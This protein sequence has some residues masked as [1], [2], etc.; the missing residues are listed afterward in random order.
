MIEKGK[1]SAAQLGLLFYSV[2]AYDGILYIPKITGKEAGHDLWLSPIWAHLLGLLF[3]LA[4]LRL[5]SMFPKETIIQY[6]ERLLGNWPGKAVGLVVILYGINLTSVVLREF[7]DFISAVFLRKTPPFIAIGGIVLLVTYAVR[8][9]LEVLGRLAQLFLP[10][11]F[12]VFGLLIILSIPEW[13]VNNILPIMGN[14]I[15]PSLKGAITPL[16]WFAGYIML[17]LYFPFVSNQRKTTAYAI[18][19]WFGIM[20]T[21]SVSGLISIFLFGK[22]VSTLNY[23]FI[24]VVRYI[25][26]GKFIQHVDALLLIVWLPGT[27]I[28]LT[29]YL[30]TASLGASQLLGLT[31]YRQLVLP[32][33]LITLVMS[34]W[35]TSGIDK[36]ETY[37]GTSQV[38]FDFFYIA[39]GLLLFITAWIR[40][41]VK[42]P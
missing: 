4:M 29:S 24:E 42:R 7:G 31:Q 20:V 23:P 30:Y 2:M 12:L 26:F 10:L 40:K 6:S 15:V 1:I 38:I 37:L 8:G 34:M 11:T 18:L 13:E 22:H 28:Q 25:G 17:G 19:T 32:I 39:L 33:G 27:F 3:V 16:S 14:G 5:S 36:F 41:R 21:L 9:G 35:R